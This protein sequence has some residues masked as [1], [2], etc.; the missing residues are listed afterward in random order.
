MRLSVVI[1]AYTD[2]RW[3]DLVAAVEST[4]HQTAL[5]HETIVVIDHNPALLARARAH[6]AGASVV[7]SDQAKGLSGARNTGWALATGDVVAFLDDDARAAP[8]WAAT[9]LTAYQEQNVVGA[10]GAVLPHWRAP[11]PRWLPDEFLWVVGCSYEGQPR[12]RAAVRN[13]IGANMSFRR[14]ILERVGGFQVALGR[15][16]ADVAGCEETELSIRACSISPGAV[17]LLEPAAIVWHTVTSQRTTR[18]YFRRRCLGEGRSKALV[19]VLVGRGPALTAERHYASRVLPAGVVRG[20]R[21]L[22]RGNVAG[23]ERSWA[24]VE[25]LALT[26]VGYGSARVR[27]SFQGIRARTSRPR[28]TSRSEGPQV[29]DLWKNA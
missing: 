15:Q 4:H 19:A 3:D 7:P 10:G 17:I 24:I 18:R 2:Q 11:R 5:V 16:G 29:E 14:D 20:L 26:A 28:A 13:A 12:A 9:L 27:A 23:A 21:E 8:D 1:C 6:L 22:G 25:G